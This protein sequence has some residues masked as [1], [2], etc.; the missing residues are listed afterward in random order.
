MKTF[1]AIQIVIL[2]MLAPILLQLC[3]GAAFAGAKVV[4]WVGS[5]GT[6]AL[7]IYTIACVRSGMGN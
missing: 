1:N 4:F 7:A 5:L 6:A 2:L 3:F